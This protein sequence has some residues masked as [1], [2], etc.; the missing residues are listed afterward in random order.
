MNIRL[1][2]V[3]ISK[4]LDITPSKTITYTNFLNNKDY[5]KL[6]NIIIENL[7]NLE[8]IID[9]NIKNN[10]HFYRLTSKLI[11]LSTITEINFDHINK[12]QEYYQKISKK[13]KENNLRIDTHPD[14][15]C[16]LN[17]TKKDIV[18]N[19]INILKYHYNI[20]NALNIKN[21]I[22]ILHIGSSV[23]GKQNS[24]K[25][26]INNFNKLPSYLKECIALE[27]DDKIYNIKDCLELCEKLNIPMVLDYHHH[28]C[29]NNNLDIDIYLKRII[30]TWK[31]INPKIHFSSPKNNTKKD[32]R[33]HHDYINPIEFIKFLDKIKNLNIDLDIMLECKA[34][35]E[36]LFRLVAQLKYHNYIFLDESTI[37]LK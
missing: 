10:I 4:T 5:N 30:N 15:F 19:S 2:Y 14:Q 25:R 6:N 21:K 32:F 23:L 33:T 31:N 1:G 28:L 16:I 27:N 17:S 26:F 29:N 18:L 24:I 35:D 7:T 20:L 11:P 13:I 9:Y 37:K 8:K 36:A 12:Y 34:K 22:I 3:S